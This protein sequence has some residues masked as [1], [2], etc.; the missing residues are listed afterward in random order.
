P[1]AAAGQRARVRSSAGEAGAAASRHGQAGGQDSVSCRN[2]FSGNSTACLEE[3]FQKRG[4]IAFADTPVDLR[5]VMARR[6]REKSNAVLN[7]TT[8][9]I[10]SAEIKP[11]DARE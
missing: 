10:G 9:G 2:R 1:A 8:F 7:R 4:T 6:R 5:P 11:P 3:I